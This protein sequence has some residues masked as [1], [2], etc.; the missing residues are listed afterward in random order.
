MKIN[1]IYTIFCLLFTFFITSFS[2]QAQQGYTIRLKAEQFTPTQNLNDFFSNR[3]SF[4]SALQDGNYY[5]LVQFSEMPNANRLQLLKS[6]GVVLDGYIPNKAYFASIPSTV[7]QSFLESVKVRSVRMIKSSWKYDLDL[8]NLPA[9]AIQEDGKADLTISYFKNV[10]FDDITLAVANQGGDFLYFDPINHQMKIR[11]ET[12]NFQKLL[13]SPLI[14]W[15]EAVEPL[16]EIDNIRSK[17]NHRSNALSANYPGGRNLQGNGVII[18]VWDTNLYPHTD[19]GTRVT[20][21]QYLYNSATSP[22][23]ANHVTG[24]IAGAGWLN[25][26][27]L[28]MAPEATVHNWNC[29]TATPDPTHVT[30]RNAAMNERIVITSNSYGFGPD[31]DNP[32]PYSGFVGNLDQLVV[33]F[34]YLTHVY[35]AGNGQN[36]CPN[37]FSTISWTHKNSLIVAATNQSSNITGFSSFGPLFDG[38]IAPIISGVGQ[39]VLSTEWD[40]TYGSKSGTSMSCPGVSGTVAQLYE[41]YRQ[42]NAGSNPQA[43]LIKAM[44]CNTADDVGNAGPDYKYGFGQIHGLRAAQAMEGSNWAVDSVSQNG[45]KTIN[46]TVPQGSAQLKATLAWTDLPGSPN[47]AISLTNDLDLFL[48][49]GTD[50]IRPWVLDPNT[51]NAVAVRG[52][53]HINNIV[54]IT[55][56]TLL[57]GS[58]DLVVNGNTITSGNQVYGLVW[59][60]YMPEIIVTH[61]FGGEKWVP[62]TLETIYWTATGT[63]GDFTLEYSVNNGTTWQLIS[64]FP[65]SQRNAT[66]N[67]PNAFTSSALVRVS[68]G[69]VIDQSDTTFTI[70]GRPNFSLTIDN[71]SPLCGEQVL[72]KWNHLPGVTEYEVLQIDSLG[73]HTIGTTTDSFF[74]INN[75]VTNYEYWFS[76]RAMNSTQGIISQRAVAKAITLMPAYDLSLEKIISPITACDLGQEFVTVRIANHG[77]KTFLIDEKIP[78]SIQLNG[79]SPLMDTITIV[80]PLGTDDEEDFTFTLPQDLSTPASFYDIVARIELAN[81]TS[82]ANNELAK[83]IIHQPTFSNIP[84]IESFESHNGYWGSGITTPTPATWEWGVPA[85][86]IINTASNGSKVWMT[87]LTGEYNQRENSNI[88]SPCFDFTNLT[89]DPYLV[90]DI[91]YNLGQIIDRGRVQYSI[92]NGTSWSN[93]GAFMLGNSNGWETKQFQLLNSIGNDKVKFR[94]LLYSDSQEE[95]GNGIALDKF[96]ISTVPIISNTSTLPTDVTLDIF[97]NPNNGQFSV[98]IQHL[99]NQK[100]QLRVMDTFG[101]LISDEQFY[102][103]SDEHILSVQLGQLAQGMYLIQLQTAEGQMT[104]KVIV[105]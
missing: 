41:R 5:V 62:N 7:S 9:H 1:Q 73:I 79:S 80:S 70:A 42:L 85:N 56:D 21:H 60:V 25:P 103:N 71:N 58:Y 67:V 61:P 43:S 11:L 99:A 72:A 90:F 28:G 88:Y 77:C 20:G 27:A 48:T 89:T 59:E 50:T 93:L 81:D 32:I 31:C 37:P 46:I 12:D 98:V 100:V 101:K 40:N 2:L 65:E 8:N 83:Q 19:F 97:P 34:P 3:S 30:M 86:S 102:I 45:S 47:A 75:L 66:I 44:V 105:R 38:R 68:A 57:A 55:A 76:V 96:Q 14:H 18:G 91:N 78:M 84:Y 10:S 33:D 26:A 35:S 82:L 51:P 13:Q 4:Q 36:D 22:D 16:L 63:T 53:D 92:N 95:V 94:V 69:N 104:K 64:T 87:S 54:Q 15:V 52:E 6:N 74:H 17:A 23:H 29:C 24:T 39:G 49:N